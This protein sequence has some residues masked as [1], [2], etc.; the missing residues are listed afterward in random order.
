[1]VACEISGIHDREMAQIL[2]LFLFLKCKLLY[3]KGKDCVSQIILLSFYK[4]LFGKVLQTRV[5]SK[6]SAFSLLGF[7]GVFRKSKTLCTILK[8]IELFHRYLTPSPASP[9]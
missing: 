4:Y 3:A 8:E 2:F 7:L 1:M 9:W 5:I 6:E